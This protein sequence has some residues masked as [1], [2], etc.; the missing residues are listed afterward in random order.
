MS[1]KLHQ[2]ARV[3]KCADLRHARVLMTERAVAIEALAQLVAR[4]LGRSTV[5]VRCSA[6]PLE[7]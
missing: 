5:L 1:S 4:G 2:S 3:G 6:H 7:S